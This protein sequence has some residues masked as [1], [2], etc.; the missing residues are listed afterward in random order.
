LDDIEMVSTRQNN[1][2]ST[3]QSGLGRKD[4]SICLIMR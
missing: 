1:Y 4:D 2:F 3:L